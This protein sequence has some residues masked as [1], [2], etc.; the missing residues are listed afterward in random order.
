M[1]I[2]ATIIPAI[3]HCMLL[4]IVW[5]YLRCTSTHCIMATPSS[6]RYIM[7]VFA[8]IRCYNCFGVCCSPLNMFT[9]IASKGCAFIVAPVYHTRKAIRNAS[10]MAKE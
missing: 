9:D 5:L 1:L 4:C 3:S 7:I 10:Y 8:L 2:T 6:S